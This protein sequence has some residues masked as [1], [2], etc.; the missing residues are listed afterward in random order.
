LAAKANRIVGNRAAQIRK[1]SL[2][3][4]FAFDPDQEADLLSARALAQAA[5][6]SAVWQR[7]DAAAARAFRRGGADANKSDLK[8]MEWR[9]NQRVNAGQATIEIAKAMAKAASDDA[10]W[11]ATV[12]DELSP[13]GSLPGRRHD[14]ELKP[15]TKRYPSPGTKRLALLHAL[16]LYERLRTLDPKSA[17]DARQAQLDL[18]LDVVSA[19][20]SAAAVVSAYEMALY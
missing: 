16:S 14:D 7:L 10:R 11:Y 19:K 3:S 18:M 20:P 12:P 6:P 13:E 9:Q 2:N 4:T 17:A 5:S 8:V 15:G 1:L